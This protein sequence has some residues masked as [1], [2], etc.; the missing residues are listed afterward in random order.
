MADQR[1]TDK[2]EKATA[3]DNDIFHVVDI[4]NT[5]QSPFG[6][7]FWMKLSTVK[8]FFKTYFDTLYVPLTRTL[9]ING[10][11][12]DLSANRSWTVSSGSITTRKTITSANL[13][14]QDITG[15]LT[16]VNGVTSFAIASNEHVIY[17]VTDTRQAFLIYP[18][19]RSIGSGETALV[20]TE[21]LEIERPKDFK[22]VS[23][24]SS[25]SVTGTTSVLKVVENILI[26]AGTFVVGDIIRIKCRL[27]RTVITSGN[28]GITMSFS[29][30]I[31]DTSANLIGSNKKYTGDVIST[32]NR[33]VQVEHD[34]IIK[35]STVSET[36]S[37]SSF[38]D[39]VQT[40]NKTTN[41]TD[42]TVDQ[43]FYI[44]LNNAQT[45]TTSF[46]TSYS[47]ERIRQT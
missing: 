6:S 26:P 33:Y 23:T 16:Y 1:L 45:D 12:F 30:T 42:W 38:F 24:A 9:T 15:F 37:F 19:N 20:S 43:Y 29:P 35:S 13:N 21:V 18:N 14:T 46:I 2:T 36:I 4:S 39:N 8:S 3:A 31:N 32:T 10:T 28:T 17:E 40:T 34:I 44:L 5:S 47:V 25:P 41:N 11:S 7:S 27:D 22:I